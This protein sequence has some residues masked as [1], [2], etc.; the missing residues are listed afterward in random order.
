MAYTYVAMVSNYSDASITT[1]D[2]SASLNVA[3]GDTLVAFVKWEGAD[4]TVALAKSTGSPANNFTIS[5]ASKVNHGS[6]DLNSCMSYVLTASADAT[7]TIRLTLGASRP[8]VRFGVLQFRPDGGDTIAFDVGAA[9]SGNGTAVAT[10]T[11]NTSGTDE[12]VVAGYGE[13]GTVTT[14]SELINAVAATEPTGSPINTYTSI[15]YR[16]LSATFTGGTASATAIGSTTDFVCSAI[17]I[18][19]TAGGAPA[20]VY[21]MT[22]LG[23][24]L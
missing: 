2:T 11:F 23:T 17:G 9:G 8:Y 7:M 6:G 4:T 22:L 13:Y 5:A 20:S 12:I 24:G 18:K 16:I 21:T 19:A 10:S 14:S 3:S 1:L 15:W